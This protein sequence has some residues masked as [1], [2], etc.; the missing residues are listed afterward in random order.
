MRR[1]ALL[2]FLLLPACTMT[3]MTGRTLSSYSV[4]HML[5][6]TLASNDL[7]MACQTGLSLSN[8]F[9]SFARVVETPHR[10][11][12]ATLSTAAYCADEAVWAAE[13]SS[14]RA[15]HKGD[16]AGL[17]DARILEKRAH[18][19]A[20]RRYY[21]SYLHT[22]EA[23]GEPGKGCPE[24][25][26][27]DELIWFLGMIAGVQAVQH[28]RACNS[29]VRV[30]TDLPAKIARGIACLNNDSW[31][32]VPEALQAA[33]WLSVPGTLPQGK[34][35][36]KLLEHAVSLGDTA[37]IR[38]ARAIQAQAAEVRGKREMLKEIL[39]AQANSLEGQAP[40]KQW[41]LL[42]AM[43][44]RQIEIIS[45]RLWTEETGHRTPL[46]ALGSFPEPPEKDEGLLDDLE[47]PEP[48]EKEPQTSKIQEEESEKEKT[49]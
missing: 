44:G 17:Q 20:A 41:R 9:L 38:L 42:D 28:D 12:A 36:W 5:P 25:S 1:A 8:M 24:L 22:V 6:Y 7:E 43:A 19:I 34:E 16:A 46:G 3:E 10:G 40:Q 49:L 39:K 21:S 31:W 32:G 48:A 15:L 35:P 45:D 18:Q 30:P 27:E 47:E 14:L 4:E 23:L 11:A 13:L 37:G 33:I 26:R 29:S 2:G